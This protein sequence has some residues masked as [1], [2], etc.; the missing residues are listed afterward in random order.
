MFYR[1]GQVLVPAGTKVTPAAWQLLRSEAAAYRATLGGRVWLERAGIVGCVGVLTLIL[2]LYVWKFQPRV[3]RNAGRALGL[4]TILLSSLLVAQ[5]AAIGPG[6]TALL[7]IGPVLLTG[8]IL[9]V[10]YDGRFSLGVSSIL[11][12][13]VT[14]GAGEKA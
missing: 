11:A 14:L 6:S 5:L 7:A 4:C 2:S 3:M 1:Q 12:V 13:L 9:S 8:M 10:A